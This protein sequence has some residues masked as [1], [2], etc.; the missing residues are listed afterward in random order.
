VESKD[1]KV[2]ASVEAT[3]YY[4]MVLT[5]AIFQ[6][7]EEKGAMTRAEVKERIEKVKARSLRLAE[8]NPKN[9]ALGRF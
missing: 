6:L 3:A 1:S 8:I 4:N 2:T 5:E 9:P 7:L